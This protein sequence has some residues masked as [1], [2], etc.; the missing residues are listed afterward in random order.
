MEHCGRAC[1]NAVTNDQEADAGSFA[2][3]AHYDRRFS[4][5]LLINGN[6]N[7][8]RDHAAEGTFSRTARG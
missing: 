7:P 6:G 2:H 4:N 8:R 1:P 5:G 3:A